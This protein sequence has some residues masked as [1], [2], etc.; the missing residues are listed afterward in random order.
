[1]SSLKKAR[2]ENVDTPFS[3][4]L[5]HNCQF[6]SERRGFLSYDKQ[7]SDTPESYLNSNDSDVMEVLISKCN[8]VTSLFSVWEIY[9]F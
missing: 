4:C 7:R 1:M 5:P 8:W 9:C 3:A 6:P 2:R